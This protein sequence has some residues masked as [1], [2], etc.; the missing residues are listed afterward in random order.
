VVRCS[1]TGTSVG[2]GPQQEQAVVNGLVNGYVAYQNQGFP[3]PALRFYYPSLDINGLF[4]IT[5]ELSGYTETFI[6]SAADPICAMRGIVWGFDSAANATI[7]IC[8]PTSGLT[9]DVLSSVARHEL[10]HAVQ[11]AYPKVAQGPWNDWV[12]EGT[13][14]AAV[15]SDTEMHRASLPIDY[16]LR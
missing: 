11:Y 16:E 2:C 7:T 4:N 6:A 13:A 3:P 14:A 15:S 9:A 12:L 1:A 10:F 8:L 5:P